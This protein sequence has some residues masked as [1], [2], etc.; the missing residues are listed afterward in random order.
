MAAENNPLDD[1]LC[2]EQWAGTP[3]FVTAQAVEDCSASL[4]PDELGYMSRFGVKRRNTFSSGRACARNVLSDLGQAFV[5]LPR[6]EDGSIVWPAGFIGSVSHTDYWAVAA[7]ARS[8]SSA[9]K[10]MGIDLEPR[11]VLNPKLLAKIATPSEVQ[12]IQDDE[13]WQSIALFSLKESLYKCLRPSYGRFISFHDVEMSELSSLR[14][15]VTFCCEELASYCD[16]QE[17]ELRLLITADHVFS[18]VWWRSE[19]L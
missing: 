7:V 1:L 19:S 16:P 11:K 14:P 3:V 10:A 4:H 13:D 2:P 12:A 9:A 17:L 18:M 5:P 8:A 15:K 6:A